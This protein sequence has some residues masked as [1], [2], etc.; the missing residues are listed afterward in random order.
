M[1]DHI[2]TFS[3]LKGLSHEVFSMFLALKLNHYFFFGAGALE[4]INLAQLL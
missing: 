4:L 3:L 2:Q 1:F